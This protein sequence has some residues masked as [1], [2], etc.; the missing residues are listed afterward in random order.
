[1]SSLPTELGI[2][3]F[4]KIGAVAAA[5]LFPILFPIL[6]PILLVALA[7]PVCCSMGWSSPL[8]I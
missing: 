8:G 1:M 3:A 4:A 5:I 6:L 2:A 7:T